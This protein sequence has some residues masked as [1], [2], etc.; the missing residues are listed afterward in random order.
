MAYIRA[1]QNG[2]YSAPST[3]DGGVV[4]TTGD[5]ACADTFRITIDTTSILATLSVAMA[6]LVAA[7]GVAATNKTGGFG[8]P[9]NSTTS[10]PSGIRFDHSMTVTRGGVSTTVPLHIRPG[11]TISLGPIV[12]VS[13]YAVSGA[14]QLWVVR[15]DLEASTIN[16]TFADFTI[17]A[18]ESSA[19]LAIVLNNTVNGGMFN[20]T[21]GNCK[22]VNP[23][24][25]L[26]MMRFFAV[27]NTSMSTAY[28]IIINGVIDGY[29]GDGIS[30][31]MEPAST[32]LPNQN[33]TYN[34]ATIG[35]NSG[36]ASY[37]KAL[38]IENV[39]N[40][41]FTSPLVIGSG[42]D[43]SDYEIDINGLRGTVLFQG[44]VTAR[45]YSLRV[46][47]VG[48][49]TFDQAIYFNK[50]SIGF[51]LLNTGV[52]RTKSIIGYGN[53]STTMDN[54]GG[55][56]VSGDSEVIIN[57]DLKYNSGT[58]MCSPMVSLMAASTKPV[59][60]TGNLDG[61]NGYVS[62]STDS[63]S[64]LW[65][66]NTRIGPITITG[67][68]YGSESGSTSSVNYSS[69]AIRYSASVATYQNLT[70][71]GNVY[72]G[73]LSPAISGHSQ[74]NVVVDVNGEVH[75][76]GLYG[77][78][79]YGPP[80]IVL[81]N[82]YA[83]VKAL[84]HHSSGT[85]PV[86]GRV[87][88]RD[89]LQAYVKVRDTSLVE[90]ILNTQINV[91]PTASDVRFGVSTGV[92]VG[93]L[94]VPQASTVLD[95]V[96]FD[97]G[98]TGTLSIGGGGTVDLSSVQTVVDAIKL[99]TDKLTFS[100]VPN[101]IPNPTNDTH[102][103]NVVL[104][105]HMNGADMSTLFTD[106]KGKDVTRIGNTV[107][108]T[109]QSKFGGSSAY[110]DGSSGLSVSDQNDFNIGLAN[111]TIEFW[112]YKISGSSQTYQK[113][114]QFGPN[115]GAP[116]GENG[117][118]VVA[119]RAT[120]NECLPF[121]DTYSGAYSSPTGWGTQP[122]QDAW[123]HLAV[124]RESDVWTIYIDG[125]VYATG[126]LAGYSISKADVY[127]G[128]NSLGGERFNGYID[129]IRIT[130]GVARYTAPFTA[131]T[132]SFNTYSLIQDGIITAIDSNV[133]SGTVVSGGG[134]SGSCD[135]T[136]VEAG[137]TAIKAKTDKITFTASGV[138]ADAGTTGGS[139]TVDLSPIT[140]AISTVDGKV[141]SIKTKT[142]QL[143]FTVDG[144][145]ADSSNSTTSVDLSPVTTAIS[146]L[147][148][149]VS[150]VKAKTDKM[151]F[152]D[153]FISD[154]SSDQDYNN[155]IFLS[156]CSGT[157]NSTIFT[158]ISPNVI[159]F[160]SGPVVSTAQSKF[161]GSSW[162]FDGSGGY[163]TVDAVDL[164]SMANFTVEMFLYIPSVS[165]G[166]QHVIGS[167]NGNTTLGWHIGVDAVGKP[168]FEVSTSGS[169]E[170]PN[171][172]NSGTAMTLNAWHHL[173][174]VK[175][176]TTYT[177]Y[178]DGVQSLRKTGGPST[179][180]NTG[181]T[182]TIGA[183][184]NNS[185]KLKG[186]IDS[187]RITGNISR[188]NSEFTP[189][190]IEFPGITGT[191]ETHIKAMPDVAA[192]ITS[193][194]TLMTLLDSKVAAVKLKTDQLSFSS[195]KVIADASVVDYT[196]QLSAITS[197]VNAISDAV[198]L[199]DAVTSKI[200]FETVYSEGDP[201]L[202]QVI[203]KAEFN[204]TNGSTVINADTGQTGT[205]QGSPSLNTAYA[206]TGVSSVALSSSIVSYGNI[207][208]LNLG[209]NDFTIEF[210]VNFSSIASSAGDYAGVVGKM[211]SN[212]DFSWICY[213]TE[214]KMNFL[215]SGTNAIATAHPTVLSAGAWYDVAISRTGDILKFYVNGV[216][217][218]VSCTGMNMTTTTAP[219]FIGR[220]AYDISSYHMFGYL[221]RLRIT[222]GTGRYNSVA[223]VSPPVSEYPTTL[224]GIA[225]SYRVVANCDSGTTIPTDLTDRLTD[226]RNRINA[227]HFIVKDE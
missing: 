225:Q 15:L 27:S 113:L 223:P 66:E 4:P 188:Y 137:I 180:Y 218:Q 184:D 186:Y 168:G 69:G 116:A 43:A 136:N 107:I 183:R 34:G 144:V 193:L 12:Y 28:N 91:I 81:Y 149:D 9:D 39:H 30:F 6:D 143:T 178:V 125:A 192:D 36:S 173:A 19:G 141:T 20:G 10:I 61:R 145:V 70:I 203:F 35:E 131:P 60:I 93:T 217:S 11:C 97:N 102:W 219:F 38:R 222:V 62:G 1:V 23:G 140:S 47:G 3:W 138:V 197:T 199:I 153:V 109:S 117:L 74:A 57:G 44:E 196:S 151:V 148:T 213:V 224:N 187:I 133:I 55:L 122:T 190:S 119:N 185:Q 206:R 17:P 221:D 59:T 159:T 85:V 191:L 41:T 220:L 51:N 83:S 104:A 210:S 58:T 194:Q 172:M 111:F 108:K 163:M 71:N 207:S 33:L 94:V 212:G 177:L 84:V 106:E 127:I 201:N 114:I 56:Y 198:D 164:H 170:S 31:H 99:K 80:G 160:T 216:L 112:F 169:Y 135:L 86:W 182:I 42:L 14:T 73:T 95:G 64:C 53:T 21:F 142:D 154:S 121:V 179:M 50:N 166:F 155:V 162:Y 147:Q 65:I 195:G 208:S 134:T 54:T 161:G 76:G 165:S 68:V 2:N 75:G 72:G 101:M 87:K 103:N 226:L 79:T 7:G 90:F 40:V 124:V 78:N 88:F 150:S 200:A 171:S 8:L 123:H 24:N 120:A 189:T 96:V 105:M 37:C 181:N 118:W 22:Y 204:G 215:T 175:N 18:V 77:V 98:T 205:N 45:Y 110:F 129:D 5:I 89:T 167:W 16:A 139:G 25:N 174:F 176:G 156:G 26:S 115:G 214:G 132:T 13:G 100:D 130:K 48:D 157:N 52:I 227:I 29:S 67:N 209:A 92:T 158:S 49:V 46:A 32:G 152:S 202:A 126:T 146:T 82:G 63:S 128:Q 211:A